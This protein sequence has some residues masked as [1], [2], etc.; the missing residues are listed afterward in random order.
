MI[1]LDALERMIAESTPGEWRT[2]QAWKHRDGDVVWYHEDCGNTGYLRAVS[3]VDGVQITGYT[4]AEYFDSTPADARA[5][6]ALHNAAPALIAKAR[7]ADRLFIA[8]VAML[9]AET[10]AGRFQIANDALTEEE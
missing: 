1:D 7:K 4:N 10:P 8:I 2:G 5:I 3:T 6:A 9:G